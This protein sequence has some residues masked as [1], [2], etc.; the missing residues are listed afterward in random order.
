MTVESRHR[1]CICEHPTARTVVVFIHGV[2]G[3]PCQFQPYIQRLGDNVS[4][5]NLLL[6]GHGGT[7]K[8]F[9][10][11]G[12]CKWQQYVDERICTLERRY[13]HIILVGHSMG[14]LLAIQAAIRY[15]ARICGLFLIATPL[16]VKMR[17]AS[18]YTNLRVAFNRVNPENK[19]DM[20]AQCGYSISDR[21]SLHQ[22]RWIPR[23]IELLKKGSAVRNS[24][25]NLK[26]PIVAVQSENDAV[27]NIK[28][29]AALH[30]A[31]PDAEILLLKKSGHFYF[32]EGEFARILSCFESFV[33]DCIVV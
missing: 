15:P 6:P 7:A 11:S 16:Y 29:I 3:S 8:A 32:E 27:V 22:L 13:D 4:F 14:T 9:A 2:L 18:V 26:I 17:K 5:I 21:L 12:M 30:L 1:E 24:L 10:D 20:A 25:I 33:A 31:L 19:A 28:S 23:F